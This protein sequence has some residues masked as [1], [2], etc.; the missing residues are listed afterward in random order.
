MNRMFALLCACTL[1]L[2]GCMNTTKTSFTTH[3]TLGESSPAITDARHGQQVL[4]ISR[5]D[6]PPWLEGTAM[7][8][9]LDYRH[10]NRVAAYGRADWI[11]PP[12]TM[13]ENLIRNTAAAG[14]GWR[15]VID[16]GST[17]TADA[18]LHLQL[19]NFS[20]VF[21]QPDQSAGLIEATATLV[22]DHD[23]SVMAQKHFRVK[24]PA[25]TPDA[26]GG[27]KA[28]GEAGRQLAAQLERWLESAVENQSVRM[29]QRSQP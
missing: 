26:Q 20:Q 1:V 17:A 15:A 3:Y 11:A 10:D 22:D 5:I 8:Y 25:S 27:A 16:P 13:L 2:G 19:E 23:G 9:R 6:A 4:R 24:V 18:D 21:A 28:L 29:N 7:H 12:A 14:G